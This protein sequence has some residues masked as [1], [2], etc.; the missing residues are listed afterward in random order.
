MRP[1]HGVVEPLA[2]I[3]VIVQLPILGQVHLGLGADAL[4]MDGHGPEEAAAADL[5]GAGV[6]E[7]V[8][9]GLGIIHGEA[10]LRAH[11]GG[12]HDHGTVAVQGDGRLH[13]ADG[14]GLLHRQAGTAAVEL[15]GRHGGDG[16]AVGD[17]EGAGIALG[18]LVG[19][20]AVQGVV[21]GDILVLAA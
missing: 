10:D 2:L 8:G 6:E 5:L 17:R 7:A 1:V 12:G 13:D 3:N 4:F 21:Q 9:G 19:I 18:V 15:I 16:G 14:F 20:G 11:G